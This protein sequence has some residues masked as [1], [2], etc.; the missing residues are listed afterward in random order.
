M[1]KFIT[2]FV[3]LSAVFSLGKGACNAQSSVSTPVSPLYAADITVE[4]NNLANQRHVKIAAAFNGWLFAAYLVNDSVSGKGGV[5]VRYSKNGGINWMPFNNYPYFRH[6]EYKACDITV[7][8]AD[9]NHLNIFVGDVR[10]DLTTKKYEVEVQR[11]IKNTSYP[12]TEVFFQ[13]LDTNKVYDMALANNYR[14][15]TSKD[16]LYNVGL[17]YS[18]GGLGKDSIVFAT[19]EKKLANKFGKP[20][21]IANAPHYRKVSLAYMHSSSIH[22]AYCAAWELLDTTYSTVGHIQFSRTIRNLDSAWNKP[23]YLDS[24]LSVTPDKLRSPSI[25]CQYNAADNDSASASIAVSYDYYNGSNFDVIGSYNMKGDSTNFWNSFVIDSTGHNEIQSN[26]S[27]DPFANNF[28]ATY[29]DSTAGALQYLSE[30]AMFTTP[31]S[32]TVN[33]TQYNNNTANLKAPWPQVIMNPS[34][35]KAFFAWVMDP[36]N[37][38]GVVLCDGEYLFTGIAEQTMSGFDVLTPYPNPANSGACLPVSSDIPV[39]LTISLY[40]TMG[41][42]MNRSTEHIGGG[43]QL[44][45][46]NTSSYAAGVYFCHIA[47]AEK[48]ITR[49][50]VV[51]H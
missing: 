23:V 45:E 41:Q 6:S 30:S 47:T 13:Q 31:R 22:G 32:W 20:V 2:F 14:Q 8:G 39:V 42:L 44:L 18:H 4:S 15:I 43:I 37:N 40:N 11:Y 26:L 17:I 46:L 25:S 38:N 24:L 7:S 33:N 35:N 19:T 16:S 21:V 28:I 1:K 36:S 9:T 27:Y 3:S 29:Y 48:T 10:M 50:L 5:V 12:S 49:R 34:N 51:E